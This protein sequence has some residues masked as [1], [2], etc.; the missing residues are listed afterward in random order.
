MFGSTILEVAIGMAFVFILLSLICSAVNEWI[1]RVFALRAGFLKN[2]IANLLDDT[3]LTDLVGKF[4]EHPLID[5][6]SRKN[7]RLPIFDAKPSYISANTFAKVLIDLLPKPDDPIENSKPQSLQG[8]YDS[9]R[10]ILVGKAKEGSQLA[11]KLLILIDSAGVDPKKVEKIKTTVEQLKGAHTQLQAL[12]ASNKDASHPEWAR[13]LSDN[14]KQM[15][16]EIKQADTELTAALQQAQ[17][18]VED[19]FDEAMERVSGWYKRRVQLILVGLALV[20]TIILNVDSIAIANSLLTN[21]AQRTLLVEL[22]NQHLAALETTVEQVST[23][24]ITATGTTS[25]SQS[26]DIT[27]G[28]VPTTTPP[29]SSTEITTT[30]TTV[31]PFK[32][33]QET[34]L[35]LGWQKTVKDEKTGKP[36]IDEKTGTEKKEQI[37]R[38]WT[39]WDWS[40]K[41]LGLF[42]TAAAVSMGAPFWFDLLSKLLN[43]RMTGKKPEN[44]TAPAAPV[45][46]SQGTGGW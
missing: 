20:V 11:K 23:H 17:K 4:Y 16:A 30:T 18:N 33:L 21:P 41:F 34:G 12:M 29:V 42:I 35:P 6:L 31:D 36:I 45:A 32:L 5:G 38:G 26:I 39:A 40:V 37:W 24:T 7:K 43:L 14:I 15:E 22:A 27:A 3:V 46:P 1:A 25:D 13:I 44:T 2:G 9:A 10:E 19:Y 8:T 28:S